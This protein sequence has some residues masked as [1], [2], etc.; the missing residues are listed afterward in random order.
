MMKTIPNIRNF[1]SL[2]LVLLG[3][4]VALFSSLPKIYQQYPII[5]AHIGLFLAALLLDFL[6]NRVKKIDDT[7]IGKTFLAFSTFKIIGGFLF[8]LPW[9]LN[10]DDSSYP[11]IIQFF[12][13]YFLYLTAEALIFIRFY[14]SKI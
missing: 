8:L 4:H 10:K 1:L 3:M 11:F 12:I 9:I 13:I 6:L 7:L 5:Y 2:F 14:L